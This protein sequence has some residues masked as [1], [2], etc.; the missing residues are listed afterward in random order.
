MAFLSFGTAALSA[1]LLV[2]QTAAPVTSDR[3]IFFK[4]HT[5]DQTELLQ[6]ATSLAIGN[7]AWESVTVS[8][9]QK[10]KAGVKWTATTRSNK[11]FCTADSDSQNPSCDRP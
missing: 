5:P 10:T 7:L 2:Q 1:L 6:R 3:R 4:P 11:Y 9:V 8:E